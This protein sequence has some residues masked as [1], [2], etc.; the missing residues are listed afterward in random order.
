MLKWFDLARDPRIAGTEGL[1]FLD[2]KPSGYFNYIPRE[3][4]EKYTRVTDVRVEGN[5]VFV[6]CENPVPVN[7]AIIF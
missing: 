2:G 6:E 5:S 4:L 3:K 1:Y 7:C